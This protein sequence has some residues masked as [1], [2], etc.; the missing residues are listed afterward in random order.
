M[1]NSNKELAHVSLS[2]FKKL[3]LITNLT[4]N[5]IGR[6]TNINMSSSILYEKGWKVFD[7]TTMSLSTGTGTGSAAAAADM[8]YVE[9]T[10]E[11]A[12]VDNRDNH[13]DENSI[14]WSY[15]HL[16]R[17]VD[18][19]NSKERNDC[20]C[21]MVLLRIYRDLLK[22]IE[23]FYSKYPILIKAFAFSFLD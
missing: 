19:D 14:I 6:H 23:S 9:R 10:D 2:A 5:W 4:P 13:D 1:N 17:A 12:G 3:N 22:K 20:N 18:V 21:K 16:N 7:S 15:S 8:S 11:K